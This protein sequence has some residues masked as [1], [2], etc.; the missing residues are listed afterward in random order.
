M[1]GQRQ[2]SY[3]SNYTA[4]QLHTKLYGSKEELE[5]TAI[6][7]LQTGLSVQR[8]S[9][10]KKKIITFAHVKDSQTL[11]FGHRNTAHTSRDRQRCSCGGCSLTRVRRPD[12]PQRTYISR[13]TEGGGGGRE[14]GTLLVSQDSVQDLKLLHYLTREIRFVAK[15]NYTT[16]Q[17]TMTHCIF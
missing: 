15:H 16:S 13:Q 10:E 12:F 3:T 2:S 8:R 6:F 11:L 1:C 9:T 17:W 4:V 14:E 5:K 7:I